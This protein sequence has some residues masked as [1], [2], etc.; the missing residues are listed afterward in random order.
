MGSCSKTFT[1]QASICRH[2]RRCH[3][4]DAMLEQINRKEKRPPRRQA[5]VQNFL[6]GFNSR[7]LLQE[8][9]ISQQ[10]KNLLERLL[11][12]DNLIQMPD[13]NIQTDVNKT[14]FDPGLLKGY[15]DIGL[16]EL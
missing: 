6:T 15:H 16:I 9:E 7:K 10:M 2:L 8:N 5:S 1:C 13:E 14:I 3:S 12:N 4:S 11:T